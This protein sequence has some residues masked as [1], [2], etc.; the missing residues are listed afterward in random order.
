MKL[1][2]SLLVFLITLGAAGAVDAQTATQTVTIQVNAINEIAFSG[3]PALVVSTATAG[4]PPASAVN[5]AA[6]WAVTTNQSG[7][8]ITAGLNAAVPAGLTLS[9][10]LAAPVGATSTGIQALTTTAVDVVT[11]LSQ[12]AAAALGVTY[13]LDATPVAGVIAPTTRIVTYTITGGV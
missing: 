11:G 13:Q 7:A 12:V 2:R 5:S 9:V 10:T 3:S 6:T 4:S 8:R 1:V